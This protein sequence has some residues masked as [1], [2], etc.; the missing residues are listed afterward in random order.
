MKDLHE[1]PSDAPCTVLREAFHDSEGDTS[2]AVEVLKRENTPVD[3]LVQ[4]GNNLPWL[5][6]HIVSPLLASHPNFSHDA[7]ERVIAELKGQWWGDDPM[8]C[9]TAWEALETARRTNIR[10]LI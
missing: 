10:D 4:I 1:L 6:V 2:A 7:Y 3:V 5:D 9:R 8:E